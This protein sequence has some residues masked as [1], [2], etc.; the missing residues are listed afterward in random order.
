MNNFEGLICVTGMGNAAQNSTDEWVKLLFPEGVIETSGDRKWVKVGNRKVYLFEVYYD[1]INQMFYEKYQGY[2]DLLSS[3]GAASSF[4]ETHGND[5][6][7]NVLDP[8]VLNASQTRFVEQYKNVY[9]LMLELGAYPN[10]SV[11]GVLSHSLGT[12]VAYEGLYKV[13]QSDYFVDGYID[14]NLIMAAPMLRPIFG[15]QNFLSDSRLLSERYLIQNASQKPYRMIGGLRTTLIKKCL[16]IYNKK[17]PF[18]LIH[19]ADFYSTSKPN[20][21]LVD[22]MIE[23]TD[24]DSNFQIKN[25]SMKESY[26]PNNKELFLETFFG[27]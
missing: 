19:D 23:F 5:V 3:A 16:A 20:N 26:I 9:E 18:Y 27:D 17:D 4:L 10:T 15:V 8:N 2:S 13:L 14:V 11:L 7:L 24:G 22:V 12:L 21:D 6:F 25:H 1:D